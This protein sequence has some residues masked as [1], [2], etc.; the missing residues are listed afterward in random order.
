MERFETAR[1][2]KFHLKDLGEAEYGVER[3]AQFMAHTRQKLTLSQVGALGLRPS[4][5]HRSLENDCLGDVARYQD[6]TRLSSAGV[7]D[8]STQCFDHHL[9]PV[10]VKSSKAVFDQEVGSP[11]EESI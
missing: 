10:R 1:L 11:L 5:L 4:G 8:Q 2:D 7:V 9:M 3:R 6:R